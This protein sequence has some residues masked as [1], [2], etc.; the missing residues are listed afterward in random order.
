MSQQH[1]PRGRGATGTAATAA[2]RRRAH[3]MR[4]R[5]GRTAEYFGVHFDLEALI[6]SVP[7]APTKA[8]LAR[9]LAV[10]DT[11]I[12]IWRNKGVFPLSVYKACVVVIGQTDDRIVA[13]AAKQELKVTVTELTK[14]AQITP[15]IREL[16]HHYDELRPGAK[17]TLADGKGFYQIPVDLTPHR[18][19]A[20]ERADAHAADAAAAAGTATTA[21]VTERTQPE[22]PRTVLDELE[23]ERSLAATLAEDPRDAAPATGASS[24]AT[25]GATTIRSLQVEQD[26]LLD[27]LTRI[28]LERNRQAIEL[29]QLKQS[30]SEREATLHTQ[31]AQIKQLQQNVREWEELA[32]KEVEHASTRLTLPSDFAETVIAGLAERLKGRG[33]STLA[34]ELER[35]QPPKMAGHRS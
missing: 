30:L 22:T 16:A 4:P 31:A 26:V 7:L 13:L 19:A 15:E 18:S 28:T 21:A 20:A 27:V 10:S 12:A 29:A 5:V 1:A 2:T 3:V 8:G 25:L 23:P 35:L 33:L 9:A 24:A 11:A 6:T 14:P 32:G 17:M 34:Q